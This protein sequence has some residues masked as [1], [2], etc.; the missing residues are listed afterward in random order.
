[1]TNLSHVAQDERTARMALSMIVEP[2]DAVTGR[3]LGELGALEVLRL[4][5]RDDRVPGLGAVDAKVWRAQFERSDSQTHAQRIVEAQRMG[6]GVLIPGDHDWPSALDD[7][8]DRQPYVLWT[9]G[10]TSFLARPLSEFVTITGARAATSYGEHVAGE[11]ASDLAN[12]ERVVVAG[13]A[14]GIEGAAH[15][16]ALAS[17]GDTIAVMA[18]GVDRP[19]PVKCRV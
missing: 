15:R 16:A 11:L 14:Y 1:M 17:G 4:A 13:G 18:N 8:D 3:L 12:A 6:I 9:R 2:D 10:A 5:K 19:Y 7:L